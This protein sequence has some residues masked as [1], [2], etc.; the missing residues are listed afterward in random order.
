LLDHHIAIWTPAALIRELVLRLTFQ[1]SRL[2]LAAQNAQYTFRQRLQF[3]FSGIQ[4]F[5]CEQS[6]HHTRL[7]A[8][9]REEPKA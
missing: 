9:K 2:L 6:R 5:R 7:A 1:F 8:K 3:I 4:H